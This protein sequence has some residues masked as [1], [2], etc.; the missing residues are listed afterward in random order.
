LPPPKTAEELRERTRAAYA[1]ITTYQDTG[2]VRSNWVNKP[3]PDELH[4]KMFY[5]EPD[6]ILLEWIRHHPYPPLRHIKSRNAV[7]STGT[8][9]HLY[10]E[11][12]TND[13]MADIP[14]ALRAAAGIS[15]RVSM[16]VPALL[17]DGMR[18]AP[19]TPVEGLLLLP[20]G[21][22]EGVPCYRIR[23]QR[24]GDT[25]EIWVGQTDYLIRKIIETPPPGF[26]DDKL[27]WIEEVHRDIEVDRAIADAVFDYQAAPICTADPWDCP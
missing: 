24:G 20:P 17:V 26:L 7:W 25:F 21:T 10:M 19:P 5:R 8:G 18:P 16:N 27:L 11:D 22:F 3:S 6:R 9:A 14:T 4:F 12:I 13:S 23:G 1:A 15:E 2:V